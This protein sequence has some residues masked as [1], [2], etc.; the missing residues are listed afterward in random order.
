LSEAERRVFYHAIHDGQ[1]QD[2]AVW[3]QLFEKHIVKRTDDGQADFQS[4]LLG[5]Y[6]LRNPETLVGSASRR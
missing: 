6:A 3:D 5:Q 2:A 4:P 1:I